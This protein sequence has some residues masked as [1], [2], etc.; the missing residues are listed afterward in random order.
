MTRENVAWAVGRVYMGLP[1]RFVTRAR[2]Y[3]LER[4]PAAGGAVYAIN[5]LHWID[6]PL[7]GALSPRDVWFVA[8][9]EAANYPVLGAFLRLHGTIAIRRGESDRDAVRKMREEA[10]HGHVI[11]L[12][13]EGTRQ[14]HGRPGTA[15]PG[16]AMVALQEDV[17]VIPVAVY[18]TQHWKI[19]NFAPCSVAFGAP[20]RFEG[21]PKGGR[22]YKEATA[23][24]ER[25]IN[26][27]FDW[28]ADVHA[29]GR[30]PGL[31]PPV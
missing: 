7:V 30:P 3:G 19:G 1:A 14:K 8:K 11:G 27:L 6:V 18:G 2:A 31:A 12:F 17:P 24:I 16:A 29:Q 22:G 13:V 25:R 9:A 5:H 10:R 28:L 26:V 4:V 15:Q 20:L 23:E 21:L